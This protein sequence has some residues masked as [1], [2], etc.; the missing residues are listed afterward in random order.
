MP[1]DSDIP[2]PPA[3][4]TWFH[5]VTHHPLPLSP[6]YAKVVC[7]EFPK[8]WLDG[9]SKHAYTI[10]LDYWNADGWVYWQARPIG[11]DAGAAVPP[12]E[13]F[14]KLFDEV[15]GLIALKA[16]AEKLFSERPWR[17]ELVRWTTD[18]R[19]AL[20]AAYAALQAV[21]L[22][23]LDDGALASHVEDAIAL[24]R[25]AVRLHG[26][27][28]VP[29]TFPFGDFFA[30]VSTWAGVDAG[31]AA[32]AAAGHAKVSTGWSSQHQAVYD[33]IRSRPDALAMLES[34][35]PAAEVL[36]AYRRRTDELGDVYREF[37]AHFGHRLATGYDFTQPRAIEVPERLVDAFRKGPPVPTYDSEKTADALRAAVPAGSRAEF[38]AALAEARHV[39]RLRDER[40]LYTDVWANGVLRGALLELGQRLVSRGS[41]AVASD[42]FEV[43]ELEIRQV[44]TGTVTLRAELASRASLRADRARRGT[45]PMIGGIP[46]APPP[47][48]WFPS[49]LARAVR[50]SFAVESALYRDRADDGTSGGTTTIRGIGVSSGTYTGCAR[51]LRSA[52]DLDRIREG[53]VLVAPITS[54]ALT[55]V[56]PLLGA[57]VTDRGGALSHAAIVTREYG[58]PGVVG[59]RDATKRIEDG[60]TVRVD[61]DSGEVTVL[62]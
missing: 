28:T 50:A 30:Q 29:S 14:E 62:T 35:A 32:L 2:T 25:K 33:A 38:D 18:D 9:A 7:E 10:Q 11:G 53:D 54:P 26:L 4:G 61:G 27:Y 31:K 51:V 43:E 55:M 6:I 1:Q 3:P 57:I 21:D 49:G 42:V 44:A 59:T 39:A 58:I 8:G 37:E 60:A 23:Q 20:E 46:K 45:P 52:D 36:E 5:D 22:R 47:S 34:R 15:P 19:P 17:E 40:S 48:E 56:L 13:I 24:L 41:L 16:Q 12:R